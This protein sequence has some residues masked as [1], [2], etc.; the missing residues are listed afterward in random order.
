MQTAYA[1]ICSSTPEG[2]ET[3]EMEKPIYRPHCSH[4]SVSFTPLP[5]SRELAGNVSSPSAIG[6][7]ASCQIPAGDVWLTG[8][9][10]ASFWACLSSGT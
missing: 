4:L 8:D 1:A 2:L 6:A 9:D 3:T 7:D 10:L 5:L